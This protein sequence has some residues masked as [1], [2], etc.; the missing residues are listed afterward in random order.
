MNKYYVSVPLFLI[1]ISLMGCATAPVPRYSSSPNTA[2]KLQEFHSTYPSVLFSVGDFSKPASAD[3]EQLCRLG[4]HISMPDNQSYTQYIRNSLVDELSLA[5]MYRDSG[6]AL[7][8]G[9]IQKIDFSSTSGTW[10]INGLINVGSESY[11]VNENYGYSTSYFGGSACRA[12]AAA[13]Q[14]AVQD[15]IKKIITNPKFKK[16]L[17]SLSAEASQD[18]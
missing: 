6:G 12:T 5:K 4:A 2:V 1:V 17:R 11:T 8:S 3:G 16:T 13:F 15:F 7:I 9:K 14:S 10:V 18:K